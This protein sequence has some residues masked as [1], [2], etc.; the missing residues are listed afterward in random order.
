MVLF[1]DSPIAPFASGTGTAVTA[2][3]TWVVPSGM[4]YLAYIKAFFVPEAPAVAEGVGAV[5]A[6]VGQDW[7]HT[8][9]EFFT[10]IGGTR[11]EAPWGQLV[12]ATPRWWPFHLPIKPGGTI[13]VTAEP[14]DALA[15]N[16]EIGIDVLYS[17]VKSGE[18]VQRLMSRETA[19]TTTTGASITI[20]GAA[21]VTDY[22]VSYVPGG[23]LVADEEVTGR[24]AVTSGALVAWQTLTLS[25]H[26][27]G[28]E[29]TS[30][31]NQ[32]ELSVAG[33]PPYD[34]LN[35]TIKDETAA[36]SSRLTETSA[37]GNAAAYAYGIGYTPK[38]ISPV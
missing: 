30:G 32:P 36:F 5:I 26:V 4:N 16:G 22:T 18:A 15:D 6:M 12:K 24:L 29:A 38:K 13:G 21:K 10:E 23:V 34:P 20:S 28:I 11:L 8:P 14:I 37:P 1:P 25:Y 31:G 27:H 7:K 17:D 19:N 35:I 2:A 9:S 33:L 3:Q